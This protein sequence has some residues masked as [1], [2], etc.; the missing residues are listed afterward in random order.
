MP[1]HR[2]QEAV[3]RGHAHATTALA[4]WRAQRPLVGVR[5][6]AFD[7]AQTRAAVATAHRVQPAD[8]SEHAIFTMLANHNAGDMML[9]NQ[10]ARYMK[11]DQ[12]PAIEVLY[13]LLL[14]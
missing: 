3:A 13:T 5:V 8:Q 1:A 2:V 12:I 4:H 11:W 7:R 9:P 6:E 14:Q 10:S